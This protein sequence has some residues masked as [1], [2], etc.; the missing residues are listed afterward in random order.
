M[1]H[2]NHMD[3]NLKEILEFV[4]YGSTVNNQ[5]KHCMVSGFSDFVY[6]SELEIKDKQFYFIQMH[7]YISLE[8]KHISILPKTNVKNDDLVGNDLDVYASS[9]GFALDIEI[10]MTIQVG[11][12]L[13]YNFGIKWIGWQRH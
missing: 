4:Y 10:V 3:N 8:C 12:H 6:P 5:P 13:S 2:D 7:E 11:L 1:V 9:R